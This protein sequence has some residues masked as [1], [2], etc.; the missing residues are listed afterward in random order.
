MIFFER[1]DLS[2]FSSQI[3][4]IAVHQAGL[5]DKLTL[6]M[7]HVLISSSNLLLSASQTFQRVTQHGMK[8]GDCR[9]K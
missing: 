8:T 4:L 3:K 5:E 9:E 6:C 7:T 2:F 1:T